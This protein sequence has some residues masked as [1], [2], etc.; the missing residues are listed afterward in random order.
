MVRKALRRFL[1]DISTPL[2]SPLQYYLFVALGGF[3][4]SLIR[5]GVVSAFVPFI[6]HR[7]DTI[8]PMSPPRTVM[9]MHMSPAR[10]P[11]QHAERAQ[12]DE[13]QEQ[14]QEWTKATEAESKPK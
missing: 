8:F 1:F 9:T 2:L 4:R 14:H 5:F 11:E 7:R 3:C 12:R 13:E 6:E 10:T